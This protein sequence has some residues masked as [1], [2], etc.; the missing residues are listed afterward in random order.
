[1]IKQALWARVLANSRMQFWLVGLLA[2]GLYANTLFH[3]FAVDD[4]IVIVKNE[5]VKKGISG[6]G[7]LLTKDTF[8]GF[9]N[10]E[11]KDKL[12]AGGRY[13]PLTP[14]VFAVIYDLFGPSAPVYHLLSVLAFSML[15]VLLLLVLKKLFVNHFG[16]EYGV[17]VALM[18][19]LLFAAHP[20]HTEAVAN[21]K[22]LD[23]TAALGF[24]LLSFLYILRAIE[25]KVNTHWMLACLFLFLGLLS[26]ENAISFLIL[27]P[28]GLFLLYKQS[29]GRS[30]RVLLI[31]LI[32]A[33]LFLCIRAQILG[34]NPI[35]GD[36]GE[37]MNNPFLKLVNNKYVLFSTEERFATIL[38]T[39]LKYISLLIFP[40]PLTY[41]YYPKQIPL[42]NFSALM[43]WLS[44][45]IH[46]MM[47][48]GIGIFGR[49]RKHFSF[50]LLFH[51]VPLSLVSNIVFPI[52]TF[53][54]ERFV[55]MSSVGFTMGLAFLLSFLHHRFP[56]LIRILILVILLLYSYK[57]LTRNMDWKNDYTLILHDAKIST[58]SAKI[59]NA[60][61]GVLLD[62]IK[63]LKDSAKIRSHILT[64]KKHLNK[65]IELHP[66][67][68]DA[69]KLLGN[70]HF[71]AKEYETAAQKYE[72]VLGMMTDDEEAFNNLHL[73]YREGARHKG[74]VENNPQGAIDFLLK[75]I[76]LKPD[77][78]ETLSLLGVAHGVKGDFAGALQYFQKAAKLNPENAEAHF[79]LYLTYQNLG[80][81]TN[82]EAALQEALKRDPK[83]MEKFNGRTQ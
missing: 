48:L 36:S 9:F 73:T 34:W 69:Y 30:L 57:T 43:P 52:G 59:N 47:V 24:S 79:N 37:L 64:A 13:R 56:G 77:D 4:G 23:E 54:G 2:F 63:T 83:I 20:I 25:E 46:L 60:V 76:K 19:V 81:K 12:V 61:G 26:K 71:M 15:C 1:M 51:L 27:I 41:D 39:L 5:F 11:G 40:H 44:M 78:A 8:R 28:A 62:E 55:F 32:P 50:A 33:F 72:F 35:A 82:A 53:M 75:A 3:D 67:Y 6:I 80:D 29:W 16:S 58:Q 65:A 10:K 22:G 66:F 31:L 70:A 68:F 14:V 18:S 45:L 49:L 21:I 42:Q 38:S 74:M 17:L 7:D